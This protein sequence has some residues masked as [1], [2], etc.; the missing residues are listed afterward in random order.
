MNIFVTVGMGR[1]PFDRLLEAVGPL[2]GSHDLVAQIGPSD[3]QF[4]CRTFR[5]L[6]F[7]QTLNYMERADLV[8]THAGNSVRL[9]Q[10]LGKVPIA[11]A[12][13]PKRGE[14][15]NSHQVD[16]LRYEERLG[17]VIPLWS[18]AQLPSL[19]ETHS[20]RQARILAQRPLPQA[21]NGTDVAALLNS[22]AK[23]WV[24]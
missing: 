3:I 24:R 21:A 2:C 22:L 5:F 13:D 12:R 10:R 23:K 18:A 20:E 14:M 7:W 1:W 17:R 4:P 11:M 9:V 19:I 6:P 16:F 15:A 8:I